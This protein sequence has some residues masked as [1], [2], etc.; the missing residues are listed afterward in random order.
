VRLKF[1]LNFD[2][3]FEVDYM[4]ADPYPKNVLVKRLIFTC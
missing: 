4:V 3:L 1:T 2:R